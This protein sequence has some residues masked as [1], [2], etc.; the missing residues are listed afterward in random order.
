[1]KRVVFLILLF[2]G[3]FGGVTAAELLPYPTDTINGE[4]VY[5][6]RVPRSI[7]LYRVSVTF[8]VSQETIIKWNPQLRERGLHYDEV[9]L[10]PSGIKPEEVTQPVN[11]EVSQ[12]TEQEVS[13]PVEQEVTQPVENT[14]PVLPV[15]QDT[16]PAVQTDTIPAIQTESIPTTPADT[17]SI[18]QIDTI[19]ATPTDSIPVVPEDTVKPLKIALLLPLQS[20][21]QQRDAGADRFVE[22]YEGALLALYDMQAKQKF[23][24]FVYD[25][26]KTEEKVRQLVEDSTLRGMDGIIGPAYP[27]Q[28][29]VIAAFALSD[30][31]LTLIPFTNKIKDIPVNPFLM[32]FNPDVKSEAKALV[33]YLETR[34]DSINIVFI[35]A[36]EA[37]IPYSV[38]EFR[39][40]A[41]NRD[42][43]VS[44][45]SVKDILADSLGKALKDSVE[46]IIVFNSEKFSN[47]QLLMP[48]VLNGKSGQQLTMYSQ[49]SW[50]KEQIL[51]P[52]IYTSVF[53]TEVPADLTHYEGLFGL[54]FRHEHKT[55]LPRF[56]LLGYDITRQMV[57]WLEGKEYYGLQS[58]IHFERISETGGF[59]NTR[60][61][62]IRK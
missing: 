40:E 36:K 61:A 17:I 8:S 60:V 29:N 15:P 45:I 12:P 9:I 34:R 49:Y 32:Q 58:D 27:A 53:A 33:D 11:Q 3:V 51:L 48:H 62:I 39:Q 26:G 30:S 38:R 24:L 1:M 35:D 4:L 25:I 22:F 7:G 57:A 13:Q 18:V 10:I 52:Q 43:S 59:I 42:L 23:E 31:V 50:Q 2:F 56:D 46:N 37:D 16:V 55:D 41:R 20:E 5:R 44:H 21:T 14:E 19:P 54:F 47:L 6:Y 28:V